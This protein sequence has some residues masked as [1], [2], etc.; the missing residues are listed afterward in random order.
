MFWGFFYS[1]ITAASVST[2]LVGE[3]TAPRLLGVQ[4]KTQE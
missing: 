1:T 3:E 4:L 2:A